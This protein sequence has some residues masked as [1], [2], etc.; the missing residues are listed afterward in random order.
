MAAS[1]TNSLGGYSAGIPPVLAIN[2]NGNIVSNVVTNGIVQASAFIYS[3]GLPLV[4]PIGGSNTQIQFNNNGVLAGSP[5]LTYIST[6]ATLNAVNFT[7]TGNVNLGNVGN[8]KILGGV[9]GYVL[10][11][12]GTGNLTWTAQTGGG[13]GNGTPGGTNTQ[14]QFNDAGDFG[15]DTGFTYDKDTNTLSVNNLTPG[16]ISTAGN[17]TAGYLIGNG[18]YLNGLDLNTA[19]YVVM[20]IQSNI[21]A[22]GT[23]SS[24]SVSGNISGSN[25][26]MLGTITSTDANFT[27]KVII[28]SNLT[29]NTGAVLRSYGNVN[30]STSPNINLGGV[31]NVHIGGGLNG[32]VLSTDGDG[33]L[34]WI[35]GGGGGGGSPGGPDTSVQYNDGG[36]FN[37]GANF[38]YNQYTY[39]LTVDN[40]QLKTANVTANLSVATNAIL[41]VYGN[42]N[43]STSK[44]ISLGSV[45]NVK[46]QGGF[47]GQVLSTDGLGNLSWIN[48]GGGGSGSP[49]GANTAV[50]FNKNG[51]FAGNSYF[52]FNE[53]TSTLNVAG[54]LV[55]NNF[56]IGSGIYE[57]CTTKVY[58]ASTASTTADQVLY[59]IPVAQISAVDFTVIATDVYNNTRQTSK[60]SAT[61][62]NGLVAY[63][64][65][66]ALHINGGVGA[67][68]VFYNPGDIV[69][70]PSLE[71]RVTPDDPA[72]TD[73]KMMIV[74]YAP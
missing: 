26:N 67:F 55:A 35:P 68:D 58:F 11:T 56:T 14:V 63:N 70:P 34:Q 42:I 36:I 72:L 65:Y 5:N 12:D 46:I 69:N 2:A 45:S 18:Y 62:Y 49:G 33:N 52:T 41:R 50:Q 27:N 37:G 59:S 16:N 51:N 66:A 20:P 6:T 57:F 71:L 21:T 7:S 3:N 30:F 61:Y 48:Q 8:V 22:V 73:Y 1:P 23:L 10:Q 17:V 9:N 43:A 53:N 29:V 24:L 19:N 31:G 74:E 4:S 15:G 60:I 38:T 25:V 54:N 47:G 39:T 32:Y 64:E 44:N 40:T 13:G 28:G